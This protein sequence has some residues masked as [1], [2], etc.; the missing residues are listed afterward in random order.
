MEFSVS[1]SEIL[2]NFFSLKEK[3]DFLYP[4]GFVEGPFE[5]IINKV[6]DPLCGKVILSHHLLDPFRAMGKAEDRRDFFLQFESKM[7]LSSS[8]EEMELIPHYPEELEALI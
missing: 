1:H 5:N 7:V 6:G 8:A 4:R 2:I 3:E